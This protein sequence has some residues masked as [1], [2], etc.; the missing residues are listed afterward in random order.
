MPVSLCHPQYLRIHLQ[1]G[2]VQD[3]AAP[4][5]LHLDILADVIAHIFHPFYL[6]KL[7]R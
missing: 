4:R 1:A 3:E 5:I 7:N 2:E 6:R